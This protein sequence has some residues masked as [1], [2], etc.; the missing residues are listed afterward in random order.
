MEKIKEEVM[1]MIAPT[2]LILFNKLIT[3]FM[4]CQ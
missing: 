2:N 1:K 4:V 3:L